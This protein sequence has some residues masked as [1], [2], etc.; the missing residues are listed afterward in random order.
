MKG[1]WFRRLLWPLTVAVLGYVLYSTPIAE[2]WKS[3]QGA[4]AWTLPVVGGSVLLVFCADAFAMGK[5]FSWFATPISYAESILVRGASYP[6]ALVNYALGQGAFAFFLHRKRGLPLGKSAATI[7]L[8]MGVNLLLLLLM[9]A[10]G[11]ALTDS[12]EIPATLQAQVRVVRI[13]IIA[14][15]AG[16]AFYGTVIAIRPRFLLRWPVFEVLLSAGISG[17]LKAMLVRVP[18]ILT[19]VVYSYLY[20]LAFGVNVPIKQALLFLPVTFL[21]AAVPLP[22]QGVGV[23]QLI[24]REIFSPYASGDVVSQQAAVVGAS[25]A[26]QFIAMM[27]QILVGLICL[28]SQLGSQLREQNPGIVPE[29]QGNHGQ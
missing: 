1:T 5:T 25:F 7:L 6:L 14:G 9:A 29:E 26:G 3:I 20:L 27:V 19:L 13:L 15:F 2:V 17:H 12:S 28:R 4:A 22:G 23:A 16:L 21:V 11:L 8:V 24:M 18:H 10:V